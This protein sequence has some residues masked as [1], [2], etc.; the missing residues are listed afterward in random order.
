MERITKI[1]AQEPAKK[2]L[3]VAAYA[4]VST[5]SDDQLISL[6]AQKKHY[7]NYINSRPEWEYAGLYYDEGISGTG[8][9]KR[10]GLQR[11]LADCER[12][13]I[14]FILVK[15]I[16]R[17]SRN[18][19]ECV[20][21]VRKLCTEGIHILFEKE[22]IDTR[23]MDGELM[24]SILSSLAESESKSISDNVKWGVK[25]RFQNGTYKIGYPPFGYANMDGQM[26]IDEDQAV[27]VRRIFAAVLVGKT[28]SVIAKELNQDGIPSKRGG[29]RGDKTITGM[30]RNEKYIG[31][32][33]LQKTYT[34]EH[35]ER[36]RNNGEKDQYY[37]KDHHP[38]IISR[39]DFKAA[40]DLIDFNAKEKGVSSGAS[41]YN[42]RY[43]FSGKIIC[44]E[45]GAKWK[46]V[47][48]TNYAA[49]T[50]CTHNRDRDK[51]SIKTIP[52]AAIEGAFTT[53]M[54]KL[55]YGRSK[56]LIPYAEM[57]KEEGKGMAL[58]RIHE[59]EDRLENVHERK[60]RLRDFLA[61]SLLDPAMFEQESGLLSK[62]EDSLKEEKQTLVDQVSGGSRQSDALDWL[63]RYT[64]QR[65]MLTAFDEEAFLEHVDHIIVISRSEVGFVMK[66]GPTF[67]EEL[68]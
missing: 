47:K 43:A 39:D 63:L 36:R 56:I 5:G 67:R 15:S 62:E 26:V 38:A 10:E 51:C 8:M 42:N 25:Q 2:K 46:R 66:C 60:N 41:K 30:I 37:I 57:L 7:R 3:R 61:K 21:T 65:E 54:N 50:C 18:T 13:R 6:E 68:L 27:V 44:G 53:M 49:Y 40:N 45:C 20:E 16:S 1:E 11:L 28:P 24:L 17:F 12:G 58:E 48:L 35:F 14:D 55:I 64:A 19:I 32:T 9:E 4:R 29:R 52:E 33:I 22:K 59:I 34:D 23:D 31:D